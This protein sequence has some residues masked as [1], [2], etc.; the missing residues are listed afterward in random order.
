M[1][2]LVMQKI[3]GY[4]PTWSSSMVKYFAPFSVRRALVA[5]QYGQYDLLKT[6]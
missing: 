4:E 6:A 3:P 1:S 5:L 2:V